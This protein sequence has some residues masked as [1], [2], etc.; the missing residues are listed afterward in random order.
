M[1]VWI[2]LFGALF[3]ALVFGLIISALIAIAYRKSLRQK[4]LILITVPLGCVAT[5][6][7]LFALVAGYSALM[8]QSDQEIFQEIFGY[9]P[10]ITDDHMISDDFGS[11]KNREIYLRAEVTKAELQKIMVKIKFERSSLTLAQANASADQRNFSWWNETD[12]FDKFSGCYNAKIYEAKGY[13]QWN[14]LVLIDCT[15]FDYPYADNRP[16]YIYVVAGRSS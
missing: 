6:L 7:A 8:H 16:D 5:P 9:K 4:W 15:I 10:S 13:N 11:Y 1:M 3:W 12:E 14:E 2:L